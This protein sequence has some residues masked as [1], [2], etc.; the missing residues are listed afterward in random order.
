MDPAIDSAGIHLSLSWWSVIS[1][2][3]I[4]WTAVC[5]CMRL[6]PLLWSLLISCFYC[7]PCGLSPRVSVSQIDPCGISATCFQ[8]LKSLKSHGISK[9][10]K[11]PA[12]PI[13]V[14]LIC[15]CLWFALSPPVS[16]WFW[17]VSEDLDL[18]SWNIPEVI[19]MSTQ[20]ITVWWRSHMFLIPVDRDC[21]FRLP[22]LDPV[23]FLNNSSKRVQCSGIKHQTIAVVIV[24]V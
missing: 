17:S 18:H 3:F 9:Y 7:C 2:S 13:S 24:N 16:L 20:Q 4:H 21:P 23:V 6:Q 15:S 10:F 22:K 8:L 14:C 5:I 1:V 11:C 12:C 19:R